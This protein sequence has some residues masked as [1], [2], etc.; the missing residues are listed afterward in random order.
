MT[1][2][3]FRQYLRARQSAPGYTEAVELLGGVNAFLM[4]C[5]RKETGQTDFRTFNDWKSAGFKVKK[6]ESSYPIFSRPSNVL[7]TE[8]GQEVGDDERRFFYICHLFHAG[9]VEQTG[10]TPKSVSGAALIG[11]TP[12]RT[13]RAE[14]V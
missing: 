4:A 5:Y 3:E 9:Q 6:G 13:D 12:S 8:K 7:K 2:D 14:A 10:E 11:F 1:K